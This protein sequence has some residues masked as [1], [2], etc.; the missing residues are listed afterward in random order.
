[1]TDNSEVAGHRPVGHPKTEMI[2]LRPL[3]LEQHLRRRQ[4]PCR[5]D[6]DRP[7]KRPQWKSS[8]LPAL[9]PLV[10]QRFLVASPVSAV[11]QHLVAKDREIERV[12]TPMYRRCPRIAPTCPQQLPLVTQ[13]L[14]SRSKLAFPLKQH[15][16]VQQCEIV[17]G[18]S[19][20]AVISQVPAVVPSVAQRGTCVVSLKQNKIDVHGAIPVPFLSSVAVNSASASPLTVNRAP[21]QS[22]QPLPR[23]HRKRSDF[24]TDD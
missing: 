2:A 16:P 8:E 22:N 15:F 24:T 5:L 4:R 11:K 10:T 18:K 3:P 23:R 17:R 21:A 6:Q 1:M 12:E 9:V 20:R 7:N 19:A 14:G 13:R